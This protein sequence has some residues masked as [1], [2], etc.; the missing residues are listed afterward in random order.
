ML[1][2]TPNA[3]RAIYHRPGTFQV[4][5]FASCLS[6][7]QLEDIFPILLHPFYVSQQ[8]VFSQT[9]L[10]FPKNK[11]SPHMEH[12][13][14]AP[15]KGTRKSQ[16]TKDASTPV[17]YCSDRCRHNKPSQA[18]N[19][20]DRRIFDAFIA[21]LDGKNPSPD[22]SQDPIASVEPPPPKLTKG[23]PKKIK[24]ETRITVSCAEIEALVFGARQDPEKSF[25]RKKNRARRG[26]LD[27]KEWKS[28]DM[29]DKDDDPESELTD[30]L[31]LESL[32]TYSPSD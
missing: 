14:T 10:L 21:L 32:H 20:V 11:T 1:E 15:F 7:P 4:L 25:G 8:I 27:A 19:S 28:V 12:K 2:E 31:Q 9:W 24:G 29:E 23:N 30:L 5:H 6:E 16:N 13:L 18:P 22:L 17:K 3:C 26:V